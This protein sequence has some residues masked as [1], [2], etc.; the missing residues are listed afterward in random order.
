MRAQGCWRPGWFVALA[1]AC[2]VGCSALRPAETQLH[3]GGAKARSYDSVAI[4]YR[5]PRQTR[6]RGDIQPVSY[7]ATPGGC[8]QYLSIA[9]PHPA[10]RPGKAL[11]ELIVARDPAELSGQSSGSWP[12]KFRRLLNDYLPGLAFAEGIESAWA[13]DVPITEVDELVD[14]L[15]RQGYFS[16]SKRPTTGAELTA[17]INGLAFSK[18]WPAVP[19]LGAPRSRACAARASWSRTTSRSRSTILVRPAT[20]SWPPPRRPDPRRSLQPR[21]STGRCT[22]CRSRPL[23]PISPSACRPSSS[24]PAAQ[25]GSATWNGHGVAGG[26][27]AAG[28]AAM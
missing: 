5:M 14:Q 15:D 20:P 13:L 8:T 7:A 10:G 24:V 28:G 6:A 23:P 4:N 27:G 2:V 11:V 1:A 19:E 3:P 12:A 17:R 9:Y 16:D 21:R 18:P 26:A 22:P 25:R